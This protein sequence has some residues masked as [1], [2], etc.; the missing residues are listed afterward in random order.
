[1]YLPYAPYKYDKLNMAV[2]SYTPNSLHTCDNAAFAFWQRALFQRVQSV[3]KIDGM[4]E[5]WQGPI[6]DFL[7][8]LLISFGYAVVAEDNSHGLYFSAASLSGVNMYY[9]PIKAVLNNP[10]LSGKELVIGKD[11]E[12]LKFTPD[13]MGITD[14]IDYYAEKLALLDTSTNTSIVNSKQ[15][16]FLFADSKAGAEALKKMIDNANEGETAVVANEAIKIQ[17]P[18][19]SE[20]ISQLKLFTAGDYIVDKLLADHSTILNNFDAEVGIPS[21]PFEK[22]ERLV[23]AEADSRKIDATARCRVWLDT[24]TESC[25]VINK[26]FGCKLK[27]VLTVD[28][29]NNEKEDSNNENDIDRNESVH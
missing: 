11:C 14:I 3:F 10:E 21:V 5:N 15:P 22:K 16:Y 23:T 29:L 7:D 9:Q 2:G 1:M 4:P 12:L 26:H 20:I 28:E 18:D 24:L 27:P 8:Y 13:Y 25:D 6:K 19:G 17:K